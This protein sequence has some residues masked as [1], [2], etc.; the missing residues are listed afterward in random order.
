MAEFIG[1]ELRLGPEELKPVVEV[2]AILE[3]MRL[4]VHPVHLADKRRHVARRV[5]VV[6]HCLVF[7]PERCSVVLRFDMVAV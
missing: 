3:A 6:R 4:R 2:D 1:I 7:G 5:E